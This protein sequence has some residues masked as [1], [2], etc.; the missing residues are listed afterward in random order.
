MLIITGRDLGK[1]LIDCLGLPKHTKRFELR[2]AHNEIV[3]I[4]C[5]YHPDMTP[6]DQGKLVSVLKEYELIERKEKSDEPSDKVERES[7]QVQGKVQGPGRE[8]QSAQELQLGAD[9]LPGGIGE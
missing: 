4:K 8:Q 3:T 9:R 7:K 6:D 2:V 1:K 5:E